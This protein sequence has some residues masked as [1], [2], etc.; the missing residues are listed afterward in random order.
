[1]KF[2]TNI[3]VGFEHTDV[4]GVVFYPRYFEM[5]SKVVERWFNEALE[6]N[7]RQFHQI[8]R[9][10]IPLVDVHCRFLRPSYLTDMLNFSLL[11][12]R[13][14]SRSATLHLEAFC[15][16]EQ[17]LEVDM[18]VVHSQVHADGIMRSAPFPSEMAAR[19]LEFLGNKGDRPL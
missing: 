15:T 18:T 14:G 19:M 17:R 10:G 5:F 16:G 11:V 9:R 12:T 8:E 1:M 4:V 2:E 6:I 13:R 7:Y 3:Q